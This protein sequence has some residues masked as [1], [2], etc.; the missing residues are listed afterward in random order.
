MT[1]C[2][3]CGHSYEDG[4]RF[5]ARDGCSLGP[6]PLDPNLGQLL[7]GQFELRERIGGGATGSVYR[8]WQHTMEREV[9]VKV[10]RRELCGDRDAKRRF[11]REARAIAR[12][13]HPGLVTVFVVG[14]TLAGAPFMVMELVPGESLGAVLATGALP[15]SRACALAREILA[16]LGCAHEAGVVHRDLKP[17]NILVATRAGQPERVKLLDFGIAKI[18]GAS[19]ESQLTTAGALFGTP[20]YLSPEQAAGDAVDARADLYACG[21]LFYRMLTGKLPFCGPSGLDV[22]LAH[23]RTPPPR[24]VGVAPALEAILARALEKDPVRRFQSAPEMA[25]AIA[26]AAAAV[27]ADANAAGPVSPAPGRAPPRVWLPFAAAASL[28]VGWLAIARMDPSPPAALPRT[29]PIAAAPAVSVPIA[30]PHL[31]TPPIAALPM[32]PPAAP[33]AS[34]TAPPRRRRSTA[35]PVIKPVAEAK[36]AAKV[37][38]DG[39]GDVARDIDPSSATPTAQAS[40]EVAAVAGPNP[41]PVAPPVEPAA[42]APAPIP[43]VPRVTPPPPLPFSPWR[44]PVRTMWPRWRIIPPPPY[45]P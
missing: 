7:A 8:A 30:A 27:V 25:E 15:P 26:S 37:A 28:L 31:V 20:D 40:D 1:A 6:A 18:L 35:A 23:L 16:A 4:L 9:A 33:V 5:C 43:A 44:A 11:H 42:P 19:A 3:R 17:E 38:A 13:S 41:R 24:P 10:L 29:L 22:V 45:H 14:E 36:P 21:V 2:A 32:G 34:T 12:L 39:A